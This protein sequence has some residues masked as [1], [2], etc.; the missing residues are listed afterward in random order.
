MRRFLLFSV[1]FALIF[2]SFVG[3]ADGD[4]D[5]DDDD[6]DTNFMGID[7]EGLGEGAQFFFV[8]TLSIVVWKPTFKW[9]RANG[10]ELFNRESREFK[11]MLGGVNRKYHTIHN[12][13]GF[14]AA[15]LGTIHGYF[16]EWH[17]TLW[18]GVAAMWMLVISGGLLQ[19]K[20]PPKEV[21]KG[22]RLLHMQRLLSVAV[23]ILLLVGHEFV[24]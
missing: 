4:D 24:D 2:A 21:R 5:D 8:F 16:L 7:M 6:D 3:S 10:P 22:A 11:R 18:A 15:L 9:L 19:W 14:L 13:S 1:L 20:W 17:W 12:W 23:V